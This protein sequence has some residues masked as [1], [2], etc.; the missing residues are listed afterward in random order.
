MVISTLD[1]VAVTISTPPSVVVAGDF[2][3]ALTI[4]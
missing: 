1:V 2:Y 4:S 3:H